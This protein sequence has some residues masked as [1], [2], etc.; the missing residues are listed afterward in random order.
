MSQ[1]I[2]VVGRLTRDPELRFTSGGKPVAQFS[3]ATSRRSKNE[4]S[5]EWEDLDTSFWD[6]TAFGPLAENLCDSFYKGLAV[7]LQ[8]NMRQEFWEKDGQKRSKWA[9]LVNAAGPDLRWGKPATQTPTE[10]ATRADYD[11][12]PFLGL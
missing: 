9:V 8:G 5:G 6:C 12:P 1:P 10:R 7:V 3:V 4:A 11:E 2:T